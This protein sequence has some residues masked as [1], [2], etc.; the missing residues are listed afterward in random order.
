MN[1]IP[2]PPEKLKL[3][4]LNSGSY[5]HLLDHIAPLAWL[6]EMPLFVT[7]EKV[8]QLAQSYYP[9]V[10][11][12]LID[13]IDLHLPFFAKNFDVLFECKSFVPHLKQLFKDFYNKD[14]LLIHC[15]HGQSDKGYAHPT[16]RH[17]ATKDAGLIYGELLQQMFY[18]NNIDCPTIFSGNYRLLFYQEHR[19]FYDDLVEKEVTSFAKGPLLLYAP[20]WN[21][22]DESTSF[23]QH[24]ESLFQHLPSDW[25]LLVKLHP[26]LEERNPSG[27]YRIEGMAQKKSN[28]R[29]L[30]EFPPVYPILA[31]ASR[32]LGDYSSVGY[33]FLFFK[34]PLFFLL[35]DR[36]PQGRLHQCGTILSSWESL[37]D[38]LTA[39]YTKQQEALYFQAFGKPKDRLSTQTHILQSLHSLRGGKTNKVCSS[40]KLG[41]KDSASKS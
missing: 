14:M 27:F 38:P 28:I 12:H 23:F 30:T 32:F 1:T 41:T 29:L 17:Y 3:A 19:S 22:L 40:P 18:E 16:L 36:L 21:D 7:D 8:F 25:S 9:M 6:L 2:V 5:I 39:D 11:T 35:Q 20:T 26:L 13:E 4:A 33:D 34:R 10:T 24:A 31:K 15:A 37:F